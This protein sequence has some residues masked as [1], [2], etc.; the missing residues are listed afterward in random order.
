MII[1]DFL[2]RAF[3]VISQLKRL[4]KKYRIIAS[5]GKNKEIEVRSMIMCNPK[6]ESLRTM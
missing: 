6:F 2:I 4:L 1:F 3:F 5:V